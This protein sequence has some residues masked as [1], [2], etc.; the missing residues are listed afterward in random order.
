MYRTANAPVFFDC[1][2]IVVRIVTSLG[3]RR[4]DAA[5]AMQAIFYIMS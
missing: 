4:Y 2:K 5:L 3:S 1:V